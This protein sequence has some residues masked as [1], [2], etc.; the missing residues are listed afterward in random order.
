M[1]KARAVF[2][3]A[4]A[5]FGQHIVVCARHGV[6]IPLVGHARR[7]DAHIYAGLG[8]VAQHLCHLMVKDEI[9][10][11]D[12]HGLFRARNELLVKG[13]AHILIIERAVSK[14]L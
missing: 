4:N 7:D 8:R 6:H 12:A 5:R 2:V 3:D 9:R 11:H 10:R 13:R 1:D 14:R